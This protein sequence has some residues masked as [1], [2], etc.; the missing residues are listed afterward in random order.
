MRFKEDIL[1]EITSTDDQHVINHVPLGDMLMIE[2]LDAIVEL[3][4]DLR[5]K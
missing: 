3:L 4:L 2:R 5:D 1:K